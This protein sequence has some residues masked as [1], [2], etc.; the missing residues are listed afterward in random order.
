M[1][2]AALK[3]IAAVV[4]LAGVGA[5]FQKIWNNHVEDSLK[6]ESG[7]AVLGIFAISVIVVH[8]FLL[9]SVKGPGKSFVQR[10]MAATM[11]KLLFYAMVLTVFM[12]FTSENKRLLAVD[13]LICYF[14][15]SI[16]EVGMLYNELRQ[17]KS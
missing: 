11:F 10:F 2:S 12:L 1:Q 13:F 4:L 17:L 8:I 9:Q 7:Y 5:F 14:V 16:L 15:F 3:F 6:L